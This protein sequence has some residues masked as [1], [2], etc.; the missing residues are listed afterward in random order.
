MKKILITAFLILNV[1]AAKIE[2]NKA[3]HY[4]DKFNGRKTA[5][6]EIFSQKKFTAATNLYPIGKKLVVIN[7]KNGDS[8]IIRVNDRISNR[9]S[10]RIDLT[11]AAFKE[12][13]NLKEGVIPVT[14]KEI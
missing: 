11:K 3:S 10:N 8:V 6:G 5:S 14:V 12:I 9:F 13:A 2:V 4:H 1:A 7:A